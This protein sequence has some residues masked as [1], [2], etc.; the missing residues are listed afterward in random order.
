MKK[1]GLNKGEGSPAWEVFKD[2]RHWIIPITIALL[3][4]FG[5]AYLVKHV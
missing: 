2:L 5:V 3:F 1:T 4:F